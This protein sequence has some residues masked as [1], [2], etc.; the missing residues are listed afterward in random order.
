MN[1]EEIIE[2]EKI[3]KE[4]CEKV[5]V[6]YHN[7]AWSVYAFIDFSR[8][9]YEQGR[10]DAFSEIAYSDDVIKEPFEKLAYEQG[11][12]QGK[13]DAWEDIDKIIN[14]MTNPIETMRII[15]EQMKEH[16]NEM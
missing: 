15:I 10:K 1:R 11:Y 4:L 5:G 12:E 6:D 7:T 13:K 14:G 8:R 2:K 3:L 16:K 9:C